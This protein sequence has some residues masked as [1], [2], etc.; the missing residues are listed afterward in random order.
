MGDSRHE[1]KQDGGG[2]QGEVLHAILVESLVAVKEVELG[3]G[4]G[5]EKWVMTSRAMMRSKAAISRFLLS[6]PRHAWQ[7]SPVPS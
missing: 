2:E 5:E 7:V 4:A 1:G 6:Q 3:W